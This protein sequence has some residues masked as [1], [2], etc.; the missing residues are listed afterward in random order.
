MINA[1]R[2]PVLG[3]AH[4]KVSTRKDYLILEKIYEIRQ[5]TEV[6]ITA[7]CD[8]IKLLVSKQ[9]L[10]FL[11]DQ[12]NAPILKL[13]PRLLK[14]HFSCTFFHFFVKNI[15]N[16][17]LPK[18]ENNFQVKHLVIFATDE[19]KFMSLVEESNN[20]RSITT[21]FSILCFG[22]TTVKQH[23]KQIHSELCMS[24]FSPVSDSGH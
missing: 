9:Q 18:M 3:L 13:T 20:L 11:G 5:T 8:Y 24:P 16:I 19:D 2:K 22:N 7:W 14:P 23:C 17:K 10:K 6:Q 1:E 4:W 21:P 15:P 12:N